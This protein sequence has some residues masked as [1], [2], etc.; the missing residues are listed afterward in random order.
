[1]VA[2]HDLIDT[3]EEDDRREILHQILSLR[4]ESEYIIFGE[5][6]QNLLISRGLLTFEGSEDEEGALL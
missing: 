2:R 1:M 4:E 6:V 5:K 3:L